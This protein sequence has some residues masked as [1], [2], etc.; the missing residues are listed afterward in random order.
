MNTLI[1]VVV[2]EVKLTFRH[3]LLLP[4]KLPPGTVVQADPFQYC[5]S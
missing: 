1:L 5:T 2:T 3:T 4:V